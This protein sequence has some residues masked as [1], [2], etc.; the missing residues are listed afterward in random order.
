MNYSTPHVF[1]RLLIP[2]IM[3]ISIAF[4]LQTSAWLYVVF[5]SIT[6]IL[7]LVMLVMQVQ[8]KRYELYLYSWMP[9]LSVF[10]FILCFFTTYTLFNYQTYSKDYFAHHRSDALLVEIRSEPQLKNSQLRFEVSVQQSIKGEKV[11]AASGK[12][13]VT[14]KIDST[15][16]AQYKDGDLLLIPAKY[17]LIEGPRNPYEFDYKTYMANHG[18][19]H[20]AYLT[21]SQVKLEGTNWSFNSFL[22]DQRKNMVRKLD[23]YIPDKEASA[24]VSTLLLGY[25][26][27]LSKDVLNTYSKTGT[28][29]VLSVSGMHVALI[30]TLAGYLLG[31]MNHSKLKIVQT[32]LFILIVWSYTLLSGF[33]AAACRA[34]IMISFVI[35]GKAMNRDQ[36]MLN[37]IAASAFFQLLIQPM[38]LFD[39]GFQLSYL[40][41]MGLILFY[42]EIYIKVQVKN[43]LLD[44]IWSCIAV[45]L[46]A[47]IATFP[48]SLYYFNQFPVFFLISN[49]FILIP[50]V[51]IMYGGICFLLIPFDF[52][53]RI[54]GTVLGKSILVLN[55]GLRIIENFPF[56]NFHGFHFGIWYYLLLY[57]LIIGFYIAFKSKTKN[58]AWLLVFIV[59][60]LVSVNSINNLLLRG[61]TS[62]V[63]YSLKNQMAIAFIR[64][65]QVTV[66]SDLKKDDPISNYSIMPLINNQNLNLES[67]TPYPTTYRTADLFFRGHC[68]QFKSWK[69]LIY[70][71]SY[72]QG[73]SQLPVVVNAILLHDNPS[74]EMTE[75]MKNYK[76]NYLII[77][78]KN[79]NY[80]IEQWTKDAEQLGLTYYILKNQKALNREDME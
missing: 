66:L 26:A 37:C 74:V 50:V 7:L 45:S 13:L 79:A 28:M 67:F 71:R 48:L 10:L 14:L 75:L 63:F 3:G 62:V 77:G 11:Q 22:I 65:G 31:F 52:I 53:L 24:L 16:T 49:L 54:L 47:Q 15:N 64:R 61:K 43:W 44:K 33:S 18:V 78:S 40:A 5:P 69:L 6:V 34:A 20:Q 29:H 38:L 56:A 21:L 72:Q 55:G 12:M 4:N 59:F 60:V 41:V 51:I 2:L 9:G 17:K 25:K 35:V 76:F 32:L 1:V 68:C 8:Y 42:P 23:K 39:V 30:M 57:C 70:D 58:I 80:K 27:D 73:V 19:Y 36:K 46:A